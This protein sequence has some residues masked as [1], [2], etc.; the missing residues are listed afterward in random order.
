MNS[1]NIINNLLVSIKT[2]YI[3]NNKYAFCKLNKLCLNILF[4]L[5]KKGLIKSYK[6]EE[7]KIKITLKYYNN[8]PLIKDF[9]NYS[10]PSLKWYL[11]NKKIMKLSKDYDYFLIST[12]KGILLSTDLSDN[13]CGGQ[14][15]FALNINL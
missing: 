3:N 8:K 14:L 5:Y 1:T 13:K 6:I 7:S 9:V 10:K 4:V 15:L 2:N 12:N 11:K